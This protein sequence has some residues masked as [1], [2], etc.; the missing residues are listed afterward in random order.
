MRIIM[1]SHHFPLPQDSI[2]HGGVQ[3]HIFQ[4]TRVLRD[5]GH[6]VEWYYPHQHPHTP[7]DLEV[8]HD[9]S[10]WDWKQ[11]DAPRTL[12][13]FHGW[14][15]KSP[16]DPAVV[17]E[18]QQ[19]SHAADE[20]IAVGEFI[21]RWY[22]G[23][24]DHVIWG[25][26]EIPERIPTPI[27]GRAVWV[28]RL[29][30]DTGA[31]LLIHHAVSAGWKVDVLGD[32]PHAESIRTYPNVKMWGFVP[33]GLVRDVVGESTIVLAAGYLSILTGYAYQRPVF[34][35]IPPGNE[36]KRDYLEL[37]P[38]PPTIIEGPQLLEEILHTQSYTT[39]STE[40]AIQ[41]RF[42]WATQQTWDAVA[43]LYEDAV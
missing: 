39:P 32:G 3:E 43:D 34:S 36:V 15:G 5:R 4:V 21:P 37:M 41:Q 12:V 2:P 31:V 11:H 26:V 18:R 28:G 13:V 19:I 22:G 24:I 38:H 7:G 42:Q 30:P 35:I 33:Q 23:K 6:T 8:T 40:E 17:A 20:T 25:G 29:A 10:A 1:R 14:E 9:Y 27:P 16:P